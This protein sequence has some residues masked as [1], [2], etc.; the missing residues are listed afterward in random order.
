L[1]TIGGIGQRSAE[2]LLA[3]IGPDMS[4]FPTDDNL[5]SWGA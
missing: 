1:D 4:P 5:V 2:N 3:E